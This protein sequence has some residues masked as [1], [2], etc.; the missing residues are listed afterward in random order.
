MGHKIFTTYATHNYIK[1][2]N[3]I[4]S[5]N[6]TTLIGRDLTDLPHQGGNAATGAFISR[7]ASVT[8]QSQIKAFKEIMAHCVLRT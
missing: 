6:I 3:L 7:A 5:V 4:G 2:Q 8:W 1:D